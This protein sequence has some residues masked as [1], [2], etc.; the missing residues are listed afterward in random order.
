MVVTF[1][2]QNGLGLGIHLT[3]QEPIIT[4]YD[5]D[6]EEYVQILIFK[7]CVITLGFIVIKLGSLYS[8]GEE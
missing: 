6:D 1:Q 2:M 7:G 4:T 8:L 5:K 3:K